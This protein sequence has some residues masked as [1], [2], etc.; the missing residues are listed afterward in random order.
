M[1]EIEE[2]DYMKSKRHVE[3]VIKKYDRCLMRIE[4]GSHPK[5]TQSFSLDMP[6]TSGGFNSKTENAAIFR[7]EGSQECY[8]YIKWVVDCLNRL[9]PVLFQI[10]WLSFFESRTNP[11]VARELNMSVSKLK[12]EKRTAV[13]MFSYALN[14]K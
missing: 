4:S 5:I 3:R 8:D 12:I 10:I 1:F 11:E 7:S 9:N 14:T 13:E 2:I 6:G